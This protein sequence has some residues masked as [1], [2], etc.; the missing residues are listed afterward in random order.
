M[1]I[2]GLLSTNIAGS[3]KRSV[4]SGWVFVCYCVGQISGP[5]FF[6]STQA[7]NYHSGI[8]AMLCGFVLNLVLNQVLRFLYARENKSREQVLVGKSEDEIADMKR[9]SEL[10]GFEDVTDKH[11]VSNTVCTIAFFYPV[12]RLIKYKGN[13]PICVIRLQGFH[14]SFNMSQVGVLGDVLGV[15]RWR[16]VALISSGP[17]KQIGHNVPNR[18]CEFDT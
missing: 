16:F 3:T 6:K 7:P 18:A 8:V 5:Q 4:A 9:E 2:L 14:T 12:S 15:L 17:S 13:V 10:Q 1:V 11:N